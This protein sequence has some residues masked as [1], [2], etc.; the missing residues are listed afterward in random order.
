[1]EMRLK[2]SAMPNNEM[3]FAEMKEC[4]GCVPEGQAQAATSIAPISP[5]D[6]FG[7]EARANALAG[8]QAQKIACLPGSVRE[9]L[10]RL[11]EA[12]CD[13]PDVEMPLQHTFAP[14]VY[15]RTIFIP[16]GTVLVGKIHKH[17]HANVL[18]MGKVTVLTES[19]GA[20]DLEG[21]LTMISE[22]GTKRA[23]YTHT[24][25]VWTTIHPTDKTDLEEIEEE[26]IAKTF[27]EY[28]QFVKRIEGG[29]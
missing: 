4:L 3:G 25:T 18:S 27:G 12:L 6:G 2:E 26:T 14:G 24:D 28:E 9:K 10:F 1:M 22:P 8:A 23:V 20:E 13:L 5:G 21:P 15:V 7:E 11:Q 16:A 29:V 19:G 17:R